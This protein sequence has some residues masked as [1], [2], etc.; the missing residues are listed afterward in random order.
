M[1]SEHDRQ[2]LPPGVLEQHRN[3]A[4]QPHVISRGD[5]LVDGDAVRA[6][7]ADGAG[8]GAD[9]EDPAGGLWVD[10][11]YLLRLAEDLR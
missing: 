7:A 9:V 6:K 3:G 5:V 2:V 1:L 10:G 11:G 4:A 8:H